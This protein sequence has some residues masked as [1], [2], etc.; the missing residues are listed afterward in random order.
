LQQA[1][2][3]GAELIPI[4]QD[5]KNFVRARFKQMQLILRLDANPNDRSR[6]VVL[7]GPDRVGGI[8]NRDAGG[9][10]A[11]TGDKVSW[12]DK[13]QPEPAE[14]PATKDFIQADSGGTFNLELVVANIS[15]GYFN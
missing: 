14:A 13:Y 7:D 10:P 12:G 5:S 9:A 15:D 6:I 11:R 1:A 3:L 8:V 4:K 2:Q